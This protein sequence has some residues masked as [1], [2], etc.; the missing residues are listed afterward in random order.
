MK[1]YDILVAIILGG[2]FIYTYIQD[3]KLKKSLNSDYNDI[4]KQAHKL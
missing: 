1:N 3:E 4:Y 2:Y